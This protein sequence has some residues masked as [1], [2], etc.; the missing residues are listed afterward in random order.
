MWRTV[1]SLLSDKI[2]YFQKISWEN[3]LKSAKFLK[4]RNKCFTNAI[5]TYKFYNPVK[6]TIW[7][8]TPPD[9]EVHSIGI[10]TT[11]I[12]VIF[13]E[14]NRIC[15]KTKWKF[16]FKKAPQTTKIPAKTLKQNSDTFWDN[17]W[18][19]FNEWI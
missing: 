16:I 3:F 2:K 5:K 11:G 6:L 18:V 1:A 12:D 17:I 9:L 7:R 8:K 4:A 14:S 10:K 15:C 19:F 13:A